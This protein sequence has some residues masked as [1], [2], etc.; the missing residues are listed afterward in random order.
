MVGALL[1]IMENLNIDH[2]TKLLILKALNHSRSIRAAAKKLKLSDAT[3]RREIDRLDICKVF[4][5]WQVGIIRETLI[6]D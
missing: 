2:H 4:G 3:L 1:N 5:T 6:E